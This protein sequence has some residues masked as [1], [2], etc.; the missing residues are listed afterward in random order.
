MVKTWSYFATGLTELL[1]MQ[2]DPFEYL[3]LLRARQQ[4]GFTS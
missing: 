4:P 3:Q 1:P 2:L